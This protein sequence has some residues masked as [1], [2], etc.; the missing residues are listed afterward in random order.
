MSPILWYRR[1]RPE[2]L[3]LQ[4]AAD[5]SDA[6][7]ELAA[8]QRAQCHTFDIADFV[9]DLVDAGVARAEK[10]HRALDSQIL[11]VGERGLSQDAFQPD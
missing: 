4:A 6:S 8:Q 7:A 1:Y 2:F 9:G 11:E 5:L 10:V 3:D